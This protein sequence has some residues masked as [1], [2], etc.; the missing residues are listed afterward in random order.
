[1]EYQILEAPTSEILTK[2]VNEALQ[3]EWVLHGSLSVISLGNND[4][5]Y[6]QAMTR[7]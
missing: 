4:T 6:Y 1:M 5:F 3:Q 7:D 2:Y